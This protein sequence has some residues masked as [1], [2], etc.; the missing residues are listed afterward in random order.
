MKE[1]GHFFQPDHIIEYSPE[2]FGFHKNFFNLPISYKSQ[3]KVQFVGI[4]SL[5]K[6]CWVKDFVPTAIVK[7]FLLIDQC[8]HE[9]SLM[10]WT[11]KNKIK[12]IINLVET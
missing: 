6:L 5:D 12:F 1:C 7:S 10:G 4:P 9:H 11:E 3:N 8:L 2:T